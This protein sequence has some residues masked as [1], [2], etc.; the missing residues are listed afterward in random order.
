MYMHRTVL[1]K[2]SN[3][4]WEVQSHTCTLKSVKQKK[5]DCLIKWDSTT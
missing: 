5:T 1:P 2:T 3:S 4:F